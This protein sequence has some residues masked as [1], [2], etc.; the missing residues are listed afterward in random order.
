M[1]KLRL[2]KVFFLNFHVKH[3]KYNSRN[4]NFLS[5]AEVNRVNLISAIVWLPG[6]DDTPTLAVVGDDYRATYFGVKKNQQVRCFFV[7]KLNFIKK[8]RKC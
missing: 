6:T 1:E 8:N 7:K 3:H 2:Q 4:W 5:V